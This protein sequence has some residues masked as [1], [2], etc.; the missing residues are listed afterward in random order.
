MSLFPL[1]FPNRGPL[2]LRP[3]ATVSLD[4]L[5]GRR[6][7]PARVRSRRRGVKETARPWSRA[8]SWLPEGHPL[9]A[10]V[11]ASRHR[12][13]VLVVAVQVPGVALFALF[14]GFPASHAL[15]EAALPAVMAALA[16]WP[17]LGKMVR[18]CLAASGLMVV[19]GIVVHLSGGNIEAHFHFFVMIP[20]AALYQ[21]WAPFGLAIW[22][23]L[24]E[25][26]IVGTLN[27]HSVYNHPGAQAHP[28][29]WAGVHAGAFAA[30]CL[31]AVVNWKFHERSRTAETKLTA[32]LAHQVRH[33]S[34]TGLPN[35]ALFHDRLDQALD[36]AETSGLLPT[37]LVLDLDGFKHVNDTFGHHFGDLVLVEVASRLRQC[38]DP[39]DTVTR[40]GGDE[41]AILLAADGSGER[42]ADTISTALA[43]PFDI[44]TVDVDLE[45]SIG[46]ATAEPGQ[47]G[48]TVTRHADAAMYV[49]KEQKLGSARYDP[50][51]DDTVIDRVHLLGELRRAL[52]ADEIVLH[53]QP[54]VALGTG[55]VVGVEALAR[56]QHPVRGLLGPHQFIQIVE[57]TTLSHEFTA[58]V[59][60]AALDQV[61]AWLDQG[62]NLPVAVN[63]SPMCLLDEQLPDRIAQKLQ[64]TGVPG[65]MLCLEITED[66]M[67][68]NQDQ[69]ID[70]LRRIG[71]LG[72]RIAVDDFGTGYSSMTYLK[73]LPVDELKVDQSF[74]HDM[75]R[76]DQRCTTLVSSVINLAHDLGLTVV[77]EGVESEETLAALR[78]LGCDVAQGNHFARP[79]NPAHLAAWLTD[80]VG[81]QG[82]DPVR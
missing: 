34:L 13:V 7:A 77:A 49:A 80:D 68:A 75:G 15:Q 33:D 8:V 18:A 21:S 36:G 10:E 74:V 11:W 63:V 38:V 23:V 41:F 6:S 67:M 22:F 32:E 69:A 43:A 81:C 51:D 9:P 76:G 25:H 4:E 5:S 24:L 55:K 70:T 54:Q 50:S 48:A 46:I 62:I 20:V 53:Y 72:V 30:A 71:R 73:T 82:R 14:R 39:G 60:V 31:G 3:G 59:L 37:V 79:L 17:R 57:H 12:L 16:C 28:W 27:S 64:S 45:A 44:E 56:W 65:D 66:T 35:P 61:R 1:Q 42:S 52:R 58:H 2:T 40:L 78:N 26:G 47:N 29:T 19:S